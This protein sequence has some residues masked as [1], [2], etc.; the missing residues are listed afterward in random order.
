MKKKAFELLE[1]RERNQLDFDI[2]S[3]ENSHNVTFP[4]CYRLFIENFTGNWASSEKLENEF[5]VPEL[6]ELRNFKTFSYSPNPNEIGIQN[7]LTLE[8]MERVLPEFEQNETIKKLGMCPV[9]ID[10]A[11]SYFMVGLTNAN[12][13]K[14]FFYS[15][16]SDSPP[17]Q[18]ATNIFEFIR[19]LEMNPLNESLFKTEYSK[20]Y[21]NWDEGYWR[22]NEG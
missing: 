22:V 5:M 11:G 6:H 13:D 15:F 18:I 1:I 16:F 2:K 20:F 12:L 3:F 7:L 8:Q 4:I 17:Q 14:I 21:K 9:A 19:C 10:T